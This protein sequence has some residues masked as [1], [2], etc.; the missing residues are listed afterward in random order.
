MNNLTEFATEKQLVNYMNT[1]TDKEIINVSRKQREKECP[2][3]Q[4][5]REKSIHTN[6]T[7]TGSNKGTDKHTDLVEGNGL[8]VQ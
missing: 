2:G 4:K 6:T 5:R 7:S 3:G 8:P 1:E